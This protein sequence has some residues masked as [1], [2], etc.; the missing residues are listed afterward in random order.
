MEYPV[1]DI[2][3]GG[4]V[5]MA[6]VSVLHVFVSH[7]AVGGGLW[8]VLTER[9]AAARDDAELR[10]FVKA[11]SRVFILVTLVFGAVTGVGI[12]ATAALISPHAILALIRIYVWG[13]AMEWVFFAVE[14]AAALVYWYGWETLSAKA[15]QA[16]GWVYFVSAFMS[17]VIINGIV[18]FMLTPGGWLESGGFWDGFFNPTYWPSLVIRSGG[19]AAMAGLFTLLTA[20]YLKRGPARTFAVRWSAAWVVAGIGVLALAG[21]WYGSALAAALPDWTALVEEAIPVLPTALSAM[22]IGAIAAVALALWPLS[23]PRTWRAPGAWLLLLAGLLLFAGG[24]WSREAARK[25]YVIHGYLYSTGM[26]TEQT[27]LLEAEGVGDHTRWRDPQ[28]A[29]PAAR[30]HDLYRAWCQPCHTLDGYNG[31]R[32]FLAHW[33]DETILEMLPRL[34]HMRAQMPPWYG[35]ET[36]TEELAAYLASVRGEA[37]AVFPDDPVAAGR[38]AWELHCGLCHTVDGYRPLRDSLAGMSRDELSDD[39]LDLLEDYADEMPP[40]LAD[41]TERDHLLDHLEAVASEET[42]EGSAS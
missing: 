23:A 1:W 32:P 27:E 28:A 22:Q 35:D 39:V 20:A 14:I 16:V 29:T 25:P 31:L 33:S 30:G 8:L 4:G 38:R 6:L 12:W 34:G 13:W 42:D 24:E 9:R 37:P 7:F 26:R 11:Q 41:E 36:D 19:S 18:T 3:M 17:L 5:L 10:A 40:Y 2:A 15:H 21:R